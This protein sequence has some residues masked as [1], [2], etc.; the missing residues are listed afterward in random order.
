MVANTPLSMNQKMVQTWTTKE[1]QNMQPKD[2]VTHSQKRGFTI[3]NMTLWYIIPLVICRLPTFSMVTYQGHSHFMMSFKSIIL[4]LKY[5]LSQSMEQ[6]ITNL[7]SRQWVTTR[8]CCFQ[9]WKMPRFMIIK[10]R[11]FHHPFPAS[12]H[13]VFTTILSVVFSQIV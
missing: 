8:M 11:V 2:G 12:N 7:N 4:H 6:A 1:L 13:E 3:L 5:D 9:L 10:G